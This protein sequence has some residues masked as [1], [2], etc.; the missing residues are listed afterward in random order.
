MKTSARETGRSDRTLKPGLYTS[1]AEHMTEE[2]T[3]WQLERNYRN[4]CKLVIF[5]GPNINHKSDFLRNELFFK[6]TK[7]EHR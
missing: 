2:K 3:K 6:V 7:W 5:F 1:Q 4:F